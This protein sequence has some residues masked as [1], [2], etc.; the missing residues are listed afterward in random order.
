MTA[1]LDAGVCAAGPVGCRLIVV[2]IELPPLDAPPVCCA[3]SGRA[4][5]LPPVC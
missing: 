3:R 1:R 4:T 5:A 2:G